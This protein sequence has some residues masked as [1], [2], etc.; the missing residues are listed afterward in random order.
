MAKVCPRQLE[1][2]ARP[3]ASACFYPTNTCTARYECALHFS[4]RCPTP[5]PLRACV[6]GCRRRSPL[7]SPL[8]RSLPTPCTSTPSRDETA[9]SAASPDAHGAPHR[10]PRPR[11]GRENLPSADNGT[12]Q[13]PFLCPTVEP[14]RRRARGAESV[15]LATPPFCS[16]TPNNTENPQKRTPQTSPKHVRE[17]RRK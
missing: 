7:T 2:P 4:C 9:Q 15:S 10:A 16:T 14:P 12:H 8:L 3:L 11:Y 13:M 5:T 1:R 6:C 17:K